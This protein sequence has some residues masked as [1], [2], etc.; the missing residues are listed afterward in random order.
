VRHFLERH[1]TTPGA[2]ITEQ[3]LTYLEN[4]PLP[5]N[6]RQ[7][8]NLVRRALILSP[9]RIELAHVASAAPGLPT[10]PTTGSTIEGRSLRDQLDDLERVLVRAA[11]ES[12]QGNQTQAA[13]RLGVS[14][15]GLAK[16]LKRLG[17]GDGSPKH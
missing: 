1:A 9:E 13:K 3:A 17:L 15:F 6:V 10:A 5:G 7:L 14:R 12:T 2:R 16:T 11:L 4:H 8:E